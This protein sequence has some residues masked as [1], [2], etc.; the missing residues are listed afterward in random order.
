MD[1]FNEEN[2]DVLG[3][4]VYRLVDPRDNK[5]FY[6]GKGCGNR[7]FNHVNDELRFSNSVD[8][9]DSNESEL[10]EKIQTIRDIRNANLKVKHFIHRFGLNEKE[11]LEVES[12]LIDTYTEL[13][14]LTNDKLGYEP[15]RGL[16][17]TDDLIK[18][19]NIV[20]Y[21]E[22]ANIDYVIVK[23]KNSTVEQYNNDRYEA[24]RQAWSLSLENVKNIRQIQ[25]VL[26]VTNGIVKEV[27]KVDDWYPSHIQ[28]KVEFHGKIAEEDVRDLF[29]GKLIPMVYRKKGLA[30]SALYKKL[31]QSVID[32][33]FPSSE[34]DMKV[35]KLAQTA[36]PR[37]I[38]EGKVSAYELDKMLTLEYS[39]KAFNLKFPV[40]ALADS[41]YE[42]KRYY[43]SPIVFNSVT[44]VLCNDW[45][46]RNDNNNRPYLE[47]WIKEHDYDNA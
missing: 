40:L 17:D 15:E 21:D 2:F 38:T 23:V 9:N 3:Y 16:I 45:Y 37:I 26:S 19:F 42:Q 39:R 7:V 31:P 11:A 47:K 43:K 33:V 41:D 24:S 13:G 14:E 44:Y 32:D 8:E 22:P 34:S 25:Y 27:Y 6:V 46:E 5:T 29:V 1:R 35:G 18:S 10:S 30:S 28:G 4:Y 36:I 20:E 12:A